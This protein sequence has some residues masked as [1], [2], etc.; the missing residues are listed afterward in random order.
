MT[1]RLVHLLTIWNTGMVLDR[2]L[3]AELIDLAPLGTFLVLPGAAGLGVSDNLQFLANL[4]DVHVRHRR[5]MACEC[6]VEVIALRVQHIELWLRM[7]W[8]TKNPGRKVFAADAKS[9]FGHV[10]GCCENAGFDADLVTQL[11][12]FNDVR[13]AAVHKYILGNI[14]YDGLRQAALDHHELDAAVVEYVEAQI[15]RPAT[16]DDLVGGSGTLIL[17]HDPTDSLGTCLTRAS[18][19]SA[20]QS[21]MTRRPS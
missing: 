10:I 13:T 7:Y 8:V 14:E 19:E 20:P 18:A 12:A 9:T 6:Y 5:A 17:V 1:N 2:A 4:K 21:G 15:A 11:R 3:A 16:A